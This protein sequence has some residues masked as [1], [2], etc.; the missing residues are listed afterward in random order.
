MTLPEMSTLTPYKSAAQKMQKQREE[1]NP[2]NDLVG[3]CQAEPSTM[4][5]NDMGEQICEEPR[6][7]AKVMRA[8]PLA[9]IPEGQEV[10]DQ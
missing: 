7:Q 8:E 6:N 9:S 3:S 2:L 10:S 5:D 1:H 4:M